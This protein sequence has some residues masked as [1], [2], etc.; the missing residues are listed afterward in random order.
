MDD[1]RRRRP[2]GQCGQDRDA[3]PASVRARHV[4][5]V[6]L[7]ALA[8]VGTGARAQAAASPRAGAS[9]WGVRA[10]V[11][12]QAIALV[13]R[14]SP[15]FAGSSYTEAYLSQP[16]L[17]SHVGAFGGRLTLIGEMN[18]EAVTLRRGELTPGIFGEG[19][20]DRRHPHTFVHEALVVVGTSPGGSARPGKLRASLAA[21][22]G[23]VP[24]GTDDP[25]N[26]PFAKYPV[27]HH[28]AQILERLVVAAGVRWR[29]VVLELSTFNGDEP[30][31]VYDNGT[32][33]RVGDSWAA[34]LTFVPDARWEAQGS[35]ATV[36]SPES[37]VGGGLDQRKV[38]WSLRYGD[39]QGRYAL[40]E[41][42]RTDEYDRGTHAFRYDAALAEAAAPV[43]WGAEVAVR[44]E[45]T[46]R[47]EEE[48][49]VNVFRTLRPHVEYLILGITRWTIVTGAV[50]APAMSVPRLS[51]VARPFMEA[52]WSR[53]TPLIARSIFIPRDFYG[54][55][56]LWSLSAG[57][58]L[59]AGATHSRMGRYGAAAAGPEGV[60]SH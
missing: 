6:A 5:V 9:R 24:F 57:V 25:M 53:P 10:S 4:A 47:P 15:A 33:E 8:A 42:A 20:V 18:L 3:T 12:A 23:F 17:M 13:T 32:I 43:W 58:R 7:F 46:A 30:V 59:R 34:R 39:H 21:G 22:K 37:A 27:N 52:S 11:G 55:S 29:P 16:A 51:A 14:A 19:Y 44:A 60:H 31:Q 28:Y 41:W 40:A 38:S 36:T 45:R 54:A 49:L 35:V 26:R 2:H 50:S 1:R 48:R 56:R